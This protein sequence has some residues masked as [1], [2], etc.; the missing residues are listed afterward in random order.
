M[1]KSAT[2]I[3]ADGMW[4]QGVCDLCRYR[5]KPVGDPICSSCQNDGQDITKMNWHRDNDIKMEMKR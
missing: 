5:K 4:V 1:T 2:E 3:M